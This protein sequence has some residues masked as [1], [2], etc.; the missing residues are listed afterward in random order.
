MMIWVLIVQ[1]SPTWPIAN[2]SGVLH[3][4]YVRFAQTFAEKQLL[5][6][7]LQGYHWM[8]SIRS[9]HLHDV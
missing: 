9:S 3:L 6:A 4:N 2:P 8:R 1:Q 5:S 7:D